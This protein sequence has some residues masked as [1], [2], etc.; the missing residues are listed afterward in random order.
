MPSLTSTETYQL[1]EFPN[2]VVNSP[3]LAAQIVAAS[4]SVPL[5]GQPQLTGSAVVLT[6]T[7]EL[8][9][10]DI[11]ALN[12][13]VAAHTGAVFGS[14]L[15]QATDTSDTTTSGSAYVTKLTLNAGPLP[16]GTYLGTLDCEHFLDTLVAS[17]FSDAL[18]SYNGSAL[19]EDSWEQAVPHVFSVVVPFTVVDGAT[20][21]LLLQYKNVGAVTVHCRRARLCIAK[22]G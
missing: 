21:T 7:G 5:A 4:L 12:A 16:A 18:L 6:F 14:T 3:V 19:Y 1:T 11:T 9:A 13:V 15:V 17:T 10:S 2:H 20:V 22:I 8:S